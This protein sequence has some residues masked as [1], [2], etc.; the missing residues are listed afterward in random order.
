MNELAIAPTIRLRR[1]PFWEG[2]EQAG[3]KAAT[4]YNHMLLP[5]VFSSAEDDYRHL[6]RH[7]QVWDVSCQRQLRLRG[8]DAG[9]LAQMMTPRLIGDMAVGKCLYVPAADRNG[10]LL[11]DPVLL[12]LAEDEFWFSLADSDLLLYALGVAGGAGLDVEIDEPDVSPLAVQGPKAEELMQRVFAP[13][14]KSLS[15]FGFGWFEFNGVRHVISRSGWSKQGG[16]EVYVHGTGN[17][18]P[19]WRALLEGGCDLKARAGCPNLPERIEGGLLSY[20]SD[21]TRENTPHEAGL[22]AYCN[23]EIAHGYLGREALLRIETKGPRRQIRCLVIDGPT[24]PACDRPWPLF[25]AGRLAGKVTS[26]SWSPDHMLNVAI[27]MIEAEFWHPG[28]SLQVELPGGETRIA[29]V[30]EKFFN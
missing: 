30:R 20:G 8:P 7:V 24:V 13:E 25:K 10:F 2:V 14:V 19:L 29:K 15:F 22:S 4:V 27:G 26:A 17:G 28:N 18:M 5:S 21:M 3:A 1:T 23:T 11:N 12:R 9:R 16:F 6:K